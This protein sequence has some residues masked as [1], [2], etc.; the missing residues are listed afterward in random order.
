MPSQKRAKELARAKFERQQARRAAA[1]ARRRRIAAFAAVGGAVVVV[2]VLLVAVMWPDGQPSA[3]P[4]STPTTGAPTPGP[5]AT[6]QGVSCTE[7][8]ATPQS[9]TY[10]KPAAEGLKPG[11]TIAFNT[12]CGVIT[13]ALAVKQ[14]PQTTNA[15]AFL[16]A[17]NWYN[18]NGCHRLT[19]EGIFVLQCGSPSL[20]GQG[21]PGFKIPDENLPKDGPNDYPA[22]TVAMA[23]SGPG[24]SGSQVFF[25][26]KDT[27][28]PAGYS[29][30]GQIVSGLDVVQYVAARG[31]SSGQGDGPPAQTIV[32][33]STTL[34]KSG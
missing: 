11:A 4:Q 16:A 17:N 18:G 26:Y 15:I 20:D 21:G 19:T 8:T 27:T 9:K 10:K 29:I 24:T 5:V 13:V 3:A 23:N 34:R 1:A 12:N 33:Q 6:P 25:V 14:A 2:V 7:A 32:I 22:G 30:L 28:L 31:L